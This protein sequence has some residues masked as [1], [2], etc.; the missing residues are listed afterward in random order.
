MPVRAPRRVGQR[1]GDQRHAVHDAGHRVDGHT[2]LGQQLVDAVEYAQ[3]RVSRRGELFVNDDAAA[4]FVEQGE[5]GEGAA[6]VDAD[7]VRRG[8]WGRRGCRRV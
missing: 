7:T 1:I 3:R 2:R 4:T 5:T 8:H 6:D